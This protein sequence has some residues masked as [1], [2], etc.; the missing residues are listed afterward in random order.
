MGKHERV[1]LDPSVLIS[2]PEP[3]AVLIGCDSFKRVRLASRVKILIFIIVYTSRLTNCLSS[4]RILSFLRCLLPVLILLHRRFL[5]GPSKSFAWS[6]LS[7]NKLLHGQHSKLE[8]KV[9]K[10][11]IF[12]NRSVNTNSVHDPRRRAA[13]KAYQS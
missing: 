11:V 2:I 13:P 5:L 12:E 1:T 8:N 4:G 10:N 9:I 7:R 6:S 3:S